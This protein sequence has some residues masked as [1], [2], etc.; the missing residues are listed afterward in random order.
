MGDRT[1]LGADLQ[2]WRLHQVLVAVTVLCV[3]FL[4]STVIIARLHFNSFFD[5]NLGELRTTIAADFGQKLELFE[6]SDAAL[7]ENFVV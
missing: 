1:D 5:K 7:E 6:V 3:F 4:P 2:R